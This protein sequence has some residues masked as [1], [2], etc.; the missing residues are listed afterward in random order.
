MIF[1]VTQQRQLRS[2][3][4]HFVSLSLR[5]VCV[6][7][8]LNVAF[9]RLPPPPFPLPPLSERH[10]QH[11]RLCGV[12]Y[13]YIYFFLFGGETISLS[14]G[15]SCLV[16]SGRNP[17]SLNPYWWQFFFWKPASSVIRSRRWV[18]IRIVHFWLCVGILK[19][20]CVDAVLM[21]ELSTKLRRYP[22]Q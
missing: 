8:R 6:E 3:M 10:N 13:I 18:K 11:F 2:V 20:V 12:W 17:I 21:I 14:V 19:T 5:S 7:Y 22:R 16:F 15:V 1:V 4:T 9:L